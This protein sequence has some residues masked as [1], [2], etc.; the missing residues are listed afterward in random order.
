VMN[1][2]QHSLPQKGC[3]N[4]QSCSSGWPI[5]LQPS[6]WWWIQSSDNQWC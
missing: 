1:K 4:P 3:L 6:K 2:K 5:P